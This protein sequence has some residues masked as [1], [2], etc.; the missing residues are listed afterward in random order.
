MGGRG[1]K[2]QGKVVWPG[3]SEVSARH[4]AKVGRNEPCPCGSRKKFKDCHQKD[5]EAFLEKLAIQEDK[6]RRDETLAGGTPSHLPWYKRLF[7]RA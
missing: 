7:R 3:F 6:R 4:V 2:M 5:G 1:F